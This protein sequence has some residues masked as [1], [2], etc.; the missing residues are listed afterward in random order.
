MIN[1]FQPT[2]GEAELAAVREVFSSGWIGRGPRTKAFEEAFGTH[3]GVEPQHLV[4]TNSCTEGLFLAMELLDIGAGDEV[5]LPAVSFVGA[6]NAIAARGARPVFCDVDPRTLNPAVDDIASSLTPRTKAVLVLHYGGAP[7]AIADIAALCRD[8]GVALVE[9]SACSVASAVDDRMCG[10]FGDIG[11]WSFDPMKIVV[12]GDGGMMYVRDPDLAARATSRVN[13]GMSQESG[14]ANAAGGGRWWDFDVEQ[15]GRRSISNDILAAIATVQL[16]RLPD[17][18]TRRAEVAKRYDHA[19]ADLGAMLCPP[20]LPSGHRSS[21]YL[22]WVQLRPEVRD[23]LAASLLESGIYTTFR[24]L[25]LH[26]LPAYG[27]TTPLPNAE[28]AA[29][30]TLCLPLHQGLDDADVAAVVKGVW[31]VVDGAR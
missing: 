31:S 27:W 19:F 1:V 21:H 28:A 18:L 17:F 7:G 11:V 2:L 8:R 6:G 13:L 25:P 30:R 9:D 10:T 23:T 29:D 14:L 12:G 16:G 4:S 24:Y 20:P 22:Y 5:V 15:F 26:R 3:L